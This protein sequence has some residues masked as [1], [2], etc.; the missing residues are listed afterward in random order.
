MLVEVAGLCVY[1]VAARKIWFYRDDWDFLAG[2]RL[3][4]HD[5]LRQHGGHLVALPLVAFRVMYYVIGL[6]SYL[7]YQLLPIV[8]HLTAAALLRVIMRRAGVNPWIA[9]VAASLFV[10]FGAGSQDVIWA[11]QI[12][13]SGPLVFGLAQLLIADHDGPIDRRDWIALALG[14]A[15]LLCSGSRSP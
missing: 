8:L 9:T 14:F 2:R 3:T 11:F 10:F 5:L 7:P 1:I 12:T 15:G 6:R 4:V 13:F